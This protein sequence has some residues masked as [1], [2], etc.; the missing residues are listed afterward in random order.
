VRTR[1]VYWVPT[2]STDRAPRGKGRL[3]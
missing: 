3:R 1:S 2:P